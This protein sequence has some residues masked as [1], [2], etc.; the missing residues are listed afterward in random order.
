METARVSVNPPAAARLPL[1]EFILLM[2]LL[3]SLVA[4]SIDAM[5]PALDQIGAELNSTSAQQTYLIVSI[6]F[7][8]M[9][10][11]QIF[12]GPFADARGRRLTILVGLIIF[13]IGTAVCYFANSIEVLLAGR[14]IQAF[15]VSGPRV[16]SMALVRD[17]Y[18]GDAMARVM[19]FTTVIFILV[20]MIAPLMG[21][22]VMVHYGWRHIFTVFAIVAV[23]SALWFFSRQKE[24]LPRAKRVK[25]S[26]PH[27]GRS[28]VWLVKQPA[29]MGPAVGMGFIFGAFLAYLSGS[30]TIF[31]DIYDTGEYFPL[32]FALLAFAIGAASLFNG[33]MV[34]RLGILK[35]VGFA[36]S[37]TVVFGFMLVGISIAY[38]GIPPLWLFISVMF[39]G[40]FFLGV[41][42]GN[43]NS[44][45]MVPVGHMAG[46]GAAF[47]GSFTSVLAVPIATF[48]NI[49]LQDD[50]APIAYGFLIFGMMTYFAVK[51][52]IKYT[53]LDS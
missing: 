44:L 24:T 6:F 45:A 23:I 43:L 4:L 36:L 27:F 48:I 39:F 52:G 10:A 34:V 22:V 15:G 51:L 26:F 32:L 5:L 16:A 21:Q 35:L 29:V 31:Q 38:A 7:V 33:I 12:F 20:P 49:F 37:M 19:S 17:L 30:Q 25:F 8:G 13:L 42:F 11:G 40:F 14:L 50:I 28:L 9:A 3:T 18:V 47:V 53:P 46:V 1:V 2:A 41:L